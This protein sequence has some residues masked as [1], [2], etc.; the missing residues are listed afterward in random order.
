ML[1]FCYFRQSSFPGLSFD[2]TGSYAACLNI[3]AVIWFVCGIFYMA[4]YISY[5]KQLCNTA[6]LTSSTEDTVG[7]IEVI[8][9]AEGYEALVDENMKNGLNSG[10]GKVTTV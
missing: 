2:L 9:T 6:A 5:R 7:R 1:N 10:I 4:L 3:C 8:P